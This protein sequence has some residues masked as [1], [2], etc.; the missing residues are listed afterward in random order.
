MIKQTLLFVLK[1]ITWYVNL[2]ILFTYNILIKYLKYI[3]CVYLINVRVHICVYMQN[4]MVHYCMSRE[5]QYRDARLT[6]GVPVLLYFFPLYQMQSV[7]E[8][9]Y[10]PTFV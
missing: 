8:V 4:E 10:R 3:K 7:S 5:Q 6:K 9:A 1:F 2:V